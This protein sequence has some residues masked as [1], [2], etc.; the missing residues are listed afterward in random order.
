M[1]CPKCG[2]HSFDHLDSCKKCGHGLAEHKAKFNLRGFYCPGLT[3]ANEPEPVASD[4]IEEEATEENG[5]ID[6]GFDFLDEPED[7]PG[8]AFAEISLGD[9]NQMLSIDQ[10]FGVDSEMIPADE[11]E[12][13]S[14]DKPDKGPEFAF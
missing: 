8:K 2:Y 7:K 13:N 10:P 11:H 9:D 12:S 6:L 14:D 5:S 4:E 1:K 3:V